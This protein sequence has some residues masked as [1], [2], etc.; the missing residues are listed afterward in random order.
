M[1]DPKHRGSSDRGSS[2]S[3]AKSPDA[4]A[5]ARAALQELRA[6]YTQVDRA[7]EGWACDRSTDC[8]RF[9]VTGREPYPTLIEIAELERAASAST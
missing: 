4:V 8:C 3:S 2:S 7:L 1:V 9:G 6:L 5:G